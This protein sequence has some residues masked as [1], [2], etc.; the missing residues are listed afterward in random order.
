MSEVYIN[1]KLIGEV[2]NPSEFVTDFKEQRRKGIISHNVNI[3]LN[4]T[5]K[6][7]YVETQKG[8]VRRPL[9]VISD[10]KGKLVYYVL[11]ADEYI[12]KPKPVAEMKIKFETGFSLSADVFKE[13]IGDAKKIT[14]KKESPRY[15]I[16]VKSNAGTITCGEKGATRIVKKFAAVHPDVRCVFKLGFDSVFQNVPGQAIKV[17]L[18]NDAPLKVESETGNMRVEYVLAPIVDQA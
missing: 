3:Y 18:H 12:P 4:E 7:I 8:R 5:T 9:I 6:D 13:I 14:T 15:T 2:G 11:T 1:N 10:G 17:F 16:E